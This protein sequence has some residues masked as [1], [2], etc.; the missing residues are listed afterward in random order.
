MPASTPEEDLL[1]SGEISFS[2]ESR[3]LRELGERLVKKPEVAVLELIKNAYDADA[4]ICTINVTAKSIITVS[5]DGHGMTLSQFKTR[6]MSVGTR[7]KEREPES[8]GFGRSITGEKG[9]GRFAVRCLGQKVTLTSVANDPDQQSRTRLIVVFDWPLVDRTEDLNKVSVPYRLETAADNASLGTS[10]EISDL[11]IDP[12]DI[13]WR[14]VRTGSISV[15]SPLRPLF[16]SIQ[17]TGRLSPKA[18]SKIDPGFELKILS[19]DREESGGNVAVE[20][21]NSFVLRAVVELTGDRISIRIF[22]R[23]KRGPLLKIVDTCKNEIGSV[24][25]DLRFFPRRPGTFDDIP[26]DGRRAYRWIKENSGVAVFDRNFRVLPYGTKGDDWLELQ[27][28][29][30]RNRRDPRSTIAEKHFKMTKQEWAAPSENW[31][32]RIP[33]SVQLVGLVQVRGRRS[34]DPKE[35]GLIASADR[36]GFVENKA[37][38]QLFQ[39]VRGA[40]EMIAVAD[41]M[42]QRRSDE[43]KRALLLQQTQEKTKAAIDEVEQSDDIPSPQKQRIVAML[44]ESQNQIERQET[45]AAER[46]SQLEIMSLLG[47]VAG[48][49]THEFGVA[50]NDLKDA[51]AE[52]RKLVRKDNKFKKLAS[53]FKDHVQRLDEFPTYSQAY[54]RG[55]R[56]ISSKSFPVRPRVRQIVKLLGTYAEERG[57]AIEVGI[58]KDVQAPPVPVTLYNGILQN[59]YTNALKAVTASRRAGSMRI[60][61]RAWNDKKWHY[62][63]V[64]DTGIGIPASLK[65]W[66][67]NPLFTTTGLDAEPLGSG[68]GLGLS[69]VKRGVEAFGG[70]VELVTAPP[71]FSTCVQVRLSW[72]QKDTDT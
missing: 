52:L 39:V 20:I 44:V 33:Q 22:E 36:E 48:Y 25:A 10:L 70:K 42:I 66:V 7:V 64:S 34:A 30:A 61:F 60:A 69:L 35:S 18:S 46:E 14:Q 13:V 40:A 28:D 53:T 62:L 43:E 23:E 21:L 71:R 58:E 26:V 55:T 68:M 1:D 72:T 27:A 19:G 8:I 29:A 4:K 6:W 47:V 31:M 38:K 57:I 59:L 63:Q 51:E 32:L 56:N 11:R 49:M 41:R 15:V 2:V 54:I 67:F 50:M 24:Q 37:Y 12:D 5:D 3:I 17:S 16:E 65:S 45:S 9:I